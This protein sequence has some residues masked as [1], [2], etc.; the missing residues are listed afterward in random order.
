LELLNLAAV[1][2]YR[3][4]RG[5]ARRGSPYGS[6]RSAR[7]GSEPRHPTPLPRRE[8]RRRRRRRRPTV[9]APPRLHLLILRSILGAVS[10]PG[11]SRGLQEL[12]RY[13][14]DSS[15]TSSVNSRRTI[16]SGATRRRRAKIS[17]PGRQK[18]TPRS[19]H[20]RWTDR[21]SDP[22]ETN[23]TV[24]VDIRNLGTLSCRHR[25]LA[26]PARPRGRLGRQEGITGR[27]ER[28]VGAQRAARVN[29]PATIHSF[30][31]RDGTGRR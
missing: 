5:E 8:K 11:Q 31:R 1:G 18:P 24:L 20:H 16:V 10:N 3:K 27:S 21:G 7:S 6:Q 25:S 23:Q 4:R 26:D 28:G 29:K 17:A 22:L 2:T 15:A 30:A 19:S 13:H 14:H 9:A 12:L